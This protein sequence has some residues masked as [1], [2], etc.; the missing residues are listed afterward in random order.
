MPDP[1]T[2]LKADHREAKKLMEQLA[3]SEEGNERKQMAKQLE[4]ALTLHM[5]LEERLLYPLVQQHV[6]QEENEEATIEHGLARE[7]LGKLGEASADM[8]RLV[9]LDRQ[10]ADWK[11]D[12][13]Y[14]GGHIER[15]R[16]MRDDWSV[17]CPPTA[18]S[19]NAN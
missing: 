1:M 2:L 14:V 3:D 15:L 17:S 7:A 11:R 6:G 18:S 5:D 4:A 19:H 12:L 13:D 16:R 9:I 8:A 10:Q